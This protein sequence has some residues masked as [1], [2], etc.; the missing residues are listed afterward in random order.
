MGNRHLPRHL[1]V[2]YQGNNA[3][4]RYYC[5]A[6]QVSNGRGSYC[7][8]IAG[9]RIEKAV[10]QSFLAAL[11][12]AGMEAAVMAAEQ[13]EADFDSS[14]KSWRLEVE[15]ARYEARRAERRYRAVDPENRLVARGLENE[16]EQSLRKLAQAEA[17]LAERGHSELA[18]D[19]VHVSWVYLGERAGAG[20]AVR[21][22]PRVKEEEDGLDGPSQVR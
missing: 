6:G 2:A 22:S 5:S 21:R 3:I 16:W 4:A 7:L 1:R 20:T 17:A 12:P 15:R 18:A 14:L 10:T 8:A 13:L 9:A 19:L 11:T